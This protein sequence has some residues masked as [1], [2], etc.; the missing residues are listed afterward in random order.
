MKGVDCFVAPLLAMTDGV[1]VLLHEVVG[2]T[3]KAAENRK[4]KTRKR[5]TRC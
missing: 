2:M 4:Q 1:H 5:Q 3:E